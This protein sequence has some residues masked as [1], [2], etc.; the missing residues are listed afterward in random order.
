MHVRRVE[1]GNPQS[2]QLTAAEQRNF[3]WAINAVNAGVQT[4][5][6]TLI[7]GLQPGIYTYKA[8]SVV[9][10]KN[11]V[12]VSVSFTDEAGQKIILVCNIRIMECGNSF[13]EGEQEVV[14][15]SKPGNQVGAATPMASAGLYYGGKGITTIS[16]QG[17]DKDMKMYTLQLSFAGK[18]TGT[19]HWDFK[20]CPCKVSSEVNK[21]V[22][23][24]AGIIIGPPGGI[25]DKYDIITCTN[26]DDDDHCAVLPM[27]GIINVHEYGPV[28][29][30][31]KGAVVGKFIKNQPNGNPID[32]I[33]RFE[34]PRYADV[35]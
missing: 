11:P 6:G 26:C 20:A 34:V 31:I 17:M 28:G 23:N 13:Q 21:D 27:E 15:F 24:V 10:S 29:G 19:Y 25:P 7:P 30:K 18:G 22:K 32:I 4:Q 14:C 33:F 3:R 2:F 5:W 16:V 12:A 1:T 35:Q 8:P 9:P